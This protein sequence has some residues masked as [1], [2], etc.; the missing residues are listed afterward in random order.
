MKHIAN[1]DNL[2]AVLQDARE[3]LPE[4]VVQ[5]I[6]QALAT[7]N[8]RSELI[9]VLHK[10]QGERGYL[11]RTDMAAVAQLLRI[12]TSTVTGVATF[13]HFFRLQKAGKYNINICTGTA[14]YV[15]GASKIVE[16]F[17]EELGIQLGETTSDGMFSLVQARCLGMCGLAPVIMIND[18]V[19]E[20]V[21]PDDVTSL[22]RT[23]SDKA[24]AVV[25]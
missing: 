5:R 21:T 24:R 23:Y 19:Y 15:R 13:Y 2:Q 25:H 10:L 20:R 11:D 8:P 6:D 16:R 1:T 9:S 12:P 17:Q 18:D 14:C 3:Q 7:S 22:I 4:T